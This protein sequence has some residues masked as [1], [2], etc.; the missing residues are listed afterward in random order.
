MTPS[1][2]EGCLDARGVEPRAGTVLCFP[3]G[4]T[5]G[6]LVHEGS[7][8][9]QGTKYIVRTDVLYMNPDHRRARQE[10]D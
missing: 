10:G 5:M 8:V 2:I 9:T 7:M 6:S 4:D 1:H 3:H